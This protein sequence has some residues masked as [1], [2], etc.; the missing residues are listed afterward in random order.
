MAGVVSRLRALV[1]QRPLARWEALRVAELQATHLLKLCEMT[2]PPVPETLVSSLP[3]LTV[4]RL[5]PIPVSASA[6]WARGRWVIVLNGAEPKTRQRMSLLHEFK[7]VLDNPFIDY[8]YR[9]TG[10]MSAAGQAEQVCDY[11]AAC[12]LMPRAWV[13]RAWGSGIQ[14]FRELAQLFHVSEGAMAI[15]LLGLGLVCTRRVRQ[16][17][18]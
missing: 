17:I 16:R 15:R 11:F 10:R 1:P 18:G 4:E 8:L 14:D 3:R 5:T 9:S 2:G 7:H 12:V 6:H 13:K